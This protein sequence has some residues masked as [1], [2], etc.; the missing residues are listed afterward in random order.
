MAKNILHICN[1]NT[2]KTSGWQNIS[3]IVALQEIKEDSDTIYLLNIH[4]TWEGNKLSSNYGFD[5][6]NRIRTERKSKAPI[7]FYSPI[8][9]AYF[10]KKSKKE[11]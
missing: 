6:A 3:S 5:I 10:E 7:I 9:P 8:Q 1:A 4:L 2:A 11:R